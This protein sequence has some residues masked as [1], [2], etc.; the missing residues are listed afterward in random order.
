[1]NLRFHPS[2]L[3]S[4]QTYELTLILPSDLTSAKSKKV[5][6]NI[7]KTIETLGG[8]VSKKD[9]WGNRKF[10]YPVKKKK[11]GVYLFYKLDLPVDKVS[12]L[13]RELEVNEDIL[14]YMMT[15]G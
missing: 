2:I 14:R 8:K 1:M 3:V 4:M 13:V 15:R 5:L 9:E 12:S 11:E 10:A 6:D 7:E